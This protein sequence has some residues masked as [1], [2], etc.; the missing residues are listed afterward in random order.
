MVPSGV[1]T[2]ESMC[3][4][5]DCTLAGN[6]PITAA[7]R[8][9]VQTAFFVGDKGDVHGGNALAGEVV[10]SVI[11]NSDS[12]VCRRVMGVSAWKG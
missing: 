5:T 7:I 11:H 9:T 8:R 4:T 3:D 1:T 2:T 12:E 10:G 6:R